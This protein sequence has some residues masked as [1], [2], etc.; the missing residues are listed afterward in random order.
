MANAL[1][2]TIDVPIAEVVQGG[3]LLNAASGDA[4]SHRI[5]RSIKDMMDAGH[6]GVGDGLRVSP[7]GQCW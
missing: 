7:S 3:S 2:P 5:E 1:Q 4:E 6:A